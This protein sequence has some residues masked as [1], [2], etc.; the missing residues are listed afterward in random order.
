MALR[1][2]SCGRTE[3]ESNV[4]HS[5]EIY[6][7]PSARGILLNF[8]VPAEFREAFLQSIERGHLMSEGEINFEA[9]IQPSWLVPGKDDH[10]RISL[11]ALN[12]HFVKDD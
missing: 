4:D 5:M 8:Y 11:E 2:D 9:S 12:F 3:R 7:R 6:L 10:L 1:L